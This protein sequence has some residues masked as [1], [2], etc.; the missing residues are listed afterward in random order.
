MYKR[1]SLFVRVVARFP[2]AVKLARSRTSGSQHGPSKGTRV[3][4]VCPT[5]EARHAQAEA[6]ATTE[7][8]LA[9]CRCVLRSYAMRYFS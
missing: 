4:H 6:R 9:S 5:P 7:V 8:V 2:H 1:L 3:S